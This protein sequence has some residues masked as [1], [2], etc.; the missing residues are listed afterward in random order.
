M[1]VRQTS[2]KYVLSI[3]KISI[4]ISK[5]TNYKRVKRVWYLL[6]EILR[7]EKLNNNFDIKG[8][9]GHRRRNE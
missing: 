9:R 5:E 7:Y 1:R 4:E 6:S 3:K 2:A 8:G